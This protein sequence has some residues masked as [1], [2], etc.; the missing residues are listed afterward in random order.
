MK[1]IFRVVVL[2]VVLSIFHGNSISQVTVGVQAG[3][4][5]AALNGHK[6]YDENKP[7]LGGAAFL[8]VDIP[9]DRAGFISIE[10]GA[11]VSQMGMRHK[12]TTESLA[13]YKIV[14]IKNNLDYAVVPLYIKE[15]FSSI[16]T[17]FGIY[18]SYLLNAQSKLSTTESKQ[19]V[20]QDP[21]KSTDK[22][23]AKNANPY[24]YGASFGFGFIKHLKSKKFRRRKGRRVLPI[25]KIDFKYNVGIA[26]ISTEKDPAMHLKNRA[27]MIAI[28]VA[29]VP[30]K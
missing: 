18:G 6:D 25:L 9:I 13:S 20:L 16:Y 5:I 21:V 23:F 27:F 29:S 11:G 3:L 2:F 1:C 12:I 28:T 24:D 14:E 19:G 4:N 8:L 7:R 26:E 15:N 10:T 22:D 17:K 30:N